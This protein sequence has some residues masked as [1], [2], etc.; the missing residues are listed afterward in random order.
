MIVGCWLRQECVKF[1][2]NYGCFGWPPACLTSS[3]MANIRNRGV[4]KTSRDSGVSAENGVSVGQVLLRFVREPGKYL[5]A[6]W[7]WKSA[8]L[9]SL[10]RAAIFFLVNLTA[11]WPAAMAAMRTELVFRGVTS[12]F[13]G[14]LTE[15]F[16]DAE[17][18]WAAAV[19]AVVVLPLASHSMELAVHWLR[20]TRNLAPSIAASVAFTAVSTLFNLYAMKRGALIVGA[21][22][23]SLLEDLRRMPRIVFDFLMLAIALVLGIFWPGRPQSGAWK[24]RENS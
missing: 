6:R 12:G 4:E 5:L 8:V 13:Y 2:E 20:G 3:A 19:G 24:A 7:N 16:S 22:R 18:P 10:F 23:E 21:G 17:P 9:S 1:A 14:A 11:G 15:G